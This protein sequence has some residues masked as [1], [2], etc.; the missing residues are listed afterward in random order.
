MAVGIVVVSHSAPLAEAAV[1][2]AMQMV[3]VDRP[4]V[5]VAAGADGGLGTDATAVAAALAEVDK[6]DGVAVLVDLGSALMSA[7]L[8]IELHGAPDS[9][10]RILPAPFVEGL[11]LAVIQ[12]S[13]GGSLDDVACEASGAMA[14]KLAAIGVPEEEPPLPAA[15]APLPEATPDTEALAEA[16]I[17]NANGLHPGPAALF[18]AEAR[19][20][21]ADVK[22]R[23]RDVGPVSAKSGIGLASLHAGKG[24]ALRLSATGP[25]AEQAVEALALF[26][27]S[28]FGE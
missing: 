17:V 12:A 25:E 4:P 26:I 6:G 28:G 22:V 20:F 5:A 19:K 16:V 23:C 18:V 11:I 13:V 27:S 8:G 21:D 1:E 15:P 14:P 9:D 2:L 10:I 7:E 24:D 3:H